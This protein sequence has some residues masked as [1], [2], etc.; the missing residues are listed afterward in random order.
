MLCCT[1]VFEDHRS[2]HPSVKE[3]NISINFLRDTFPSIP[4]SEFLILAKQMAAE[5]VPLWWTK[6]TMKQTNTYEM[7]AS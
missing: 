3:R 2:F 6:Q 5:K 7:K 1:Y 4:T